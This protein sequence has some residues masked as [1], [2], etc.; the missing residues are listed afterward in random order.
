MITFKLDS[1]DC[2]ITLRTSGTEPKIKYYIELSGESKEDAEKELKVVFD[3][4]I[5]ALNVRKY[6]L[7]K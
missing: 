3:G 4:M 6:N 7:L 2:A 5:S 1:N